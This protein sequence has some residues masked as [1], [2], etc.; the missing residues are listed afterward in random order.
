MRYV[1]GIHVDIS[2]PKRS[3]HSLPQAKNSMG[4]FKL[5][6]FQSIKKSSMNQSNTGQMAATLLFTDKTRKQNGNCMKLASKQFS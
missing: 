6:F 2:T 5:N 3:K 1:S 4:K